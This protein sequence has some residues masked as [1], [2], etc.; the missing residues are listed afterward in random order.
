Y[1]APSLKFFLPDLPPPKQVTGKLKQ[2]AMRNTSDMRQRKYIFITTSD[3][4]RTDYVAGRLKSPLKN[5]R[6]VCDSL[7]ARNPTSLACEWMFRRDNLQISILVP[8]RSA[9]NLVPQLDKTALA[10]LPSA[11]RTQSTSPRPARLRGI[12][13]G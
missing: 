11:F 6:C 13:I 10:A 9:P 12:A 1:F 7:S 2:I 3:R 4:N 5:R 8:S